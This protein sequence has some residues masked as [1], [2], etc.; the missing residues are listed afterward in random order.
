MLDFGGLGAWRT[1]WHQGLA[2]KE[3]IGAKIVECSPRWVEVFVSVFQFLPRFFDLSSTKSNGSMPS[4]YRMTLV[5][6]SCLRPSIRINGEGCRRRKQEPFWSNH[7]S[8]TSASCTRARKGCQS[9]SFLS[10]TSE[11][12]RRSLNKYEIQYSFL[13]FCLLS[14][15]LFGSAFLSFCSAF[16]SFLSISL[17]FCSATRWLRTPNR[18]PSRSLPLGPPY[19]AKS[20]RRNK[21]NSR[22][23]RLWMN[24][25]QQETGRTWSGLG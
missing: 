8:V 24:R 13:F 17:C 9:S 16:E 7:V 1:H 3:T 19:P 6:Y 11:W 18:S 25:K 20:S 14:T 21:T 10:F 4:D 23:A 2:I 22:T 12:F 5:A 15:V